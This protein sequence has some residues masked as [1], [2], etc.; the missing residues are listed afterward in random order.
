M[1][2]ITSLSKKFGIILGFASFFIGLMVIIA[3]GEEFI[4]LKIPEGKEFIGFVFFILGLFTL[5]ET[6]FSEKIK[7]K[8]QKA[9]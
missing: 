7:F 3:P 4:F 9:H 2:I 5:K 6:G 8:K 1:K